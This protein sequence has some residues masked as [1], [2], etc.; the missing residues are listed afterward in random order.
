MADVE[1][2]RRVAE[3]LI[4]IRAVHCNLETPFVFTSG[5]LSPVYVDIRRLISF[6]D[7][8]REVMDLAARLVEEAVG[9]GGFDVVAGGETA[10]I[11]YAAW[12]A[13]RFGKPMIYVRKQPKTFGRMSQIEGQL[14]AGQRVLLVEDLITDGGS[15]FT[16]LRGIR[17]AGARV[18]HLLVIFEYGTVAE[19]RPALAAEGV[20]LH[21]LTT[22]GTLLEVAETKGYFTTQ[23]V[24][25]T[26]R[27]LADP[28]GWGAGRRPAGA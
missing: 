24:A 14:D 7:E 5:T 4:R 8:R 20:T 25:E 27:F 2:A 15:K 12:V 10:G 11:P 9:A 26:R 28:K 23:E 19:T 17:Q 22:W 6:P 1:R 18:E 13:E 21:S 3:H 16:F